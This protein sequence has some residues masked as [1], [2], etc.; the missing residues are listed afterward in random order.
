MALAPVIVSGTCQVC[1]RPFEYE[2]KGGR[3]RP[4]LYCSDLCTDLIHVLERVSKAVEAWKPYKG[5][6]P[7]RVLEVASELHA[8]ANTLKA[9]A[10]K[11][12][13]A[14]KAQLSMLAPTADKA[15]KGRRVRA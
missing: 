9:K 14:P 5:A 8:H 11:G 1:G 4:R 7:G 13:R 3:G 15:V 12:T 6:T 10:G 2:C